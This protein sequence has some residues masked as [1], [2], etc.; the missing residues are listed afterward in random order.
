ML[1]LNFM[2]EH[3]LLWF[4][5]KAKPGRGLTSKNQG[6]AFGVI[7]KLA[8]LMLSLPLFFLCNCLLSVN[9]KKK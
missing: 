7:E 8:I 4:F 3:C 6:T 9:T 1:I 5:L 2:A